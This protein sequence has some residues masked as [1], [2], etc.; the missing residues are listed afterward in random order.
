MH[1]DRHSFKNGWVCEG[2]MC[3]TIFFRDFRISLPDLPVG[4]VHCGTFFWFD[5]DSTVRP[6]LLC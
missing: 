5:L 2:K 1:S 3:Y 4:D 6:V